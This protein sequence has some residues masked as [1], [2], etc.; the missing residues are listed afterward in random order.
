MRDLLAP[1][2][3]FLAARCI[4]NQMV[5][6]QQGLDSSFK[7]LADATRRAV[8][9]RLADGPDGVTSLAEEHGITVAGMLKH[10]RVLEEAG[11]VRSETE[12]RE[13]SAAY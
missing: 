1:K 4:V 9:L 11:M 8:L 2:F 6:Y 7:A 5:N 12:I 13:T 3:D 10:L